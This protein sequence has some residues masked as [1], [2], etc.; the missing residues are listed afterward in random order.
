MKPRHAHMGF[1]NFC[2]LWLL[3][4]HLGFE[5]FCELWLLSKWYDSK[6]KKQK[7]KETKPWYNST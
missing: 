4:A 1:E 7:S 5:N 3:Y 2:E 6:E